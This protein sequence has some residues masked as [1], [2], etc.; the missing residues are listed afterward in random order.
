M[1]KNILYQNLDILSVMEACEDKSKDFILLFMPT[2]MGGTV[3][4][5]SRQRKISTAYDEWYHE[6][7]REYADF[8][9]LYFSD[10]N[11]YND[12]VT[13][14]KKVIQNAGRILGDEGIFCFAVPQVIKLLGYETLEALNVQ[15]LLEQTF[16]YC[17]ALPMPSFS[18]ET[19]EKIGCGEKLSTGR[20]FTVGATPYTLYVCSNC[21][22]KMC[23]RNWSIYGIK[24]PPNAIV[25]DFLEKNADEIT[26]QNYAGL[27]ERE[28][29]K[30]PGSIAIRLFNTL[31]IRELRQRNILEAVE[32]MSFSSY[33]IAGKN[34]EEI[35]QFENV[36]A[37]LR[38]DTLSILNDKN[39]WTSICECLIYTLYE[40]QKDARVLFPF[41]RN[42]EC[43]S[44]AN[45]LGLNW[46]SLYKISLCNKEIWY[47]GENRSAFDCPELKR[48]D[49]YPIRYQHVDYLK[50]IEPRDY[51]IQTTAKQ[52][53]TVYYDENVV[54]SVAEINKMKQRVAKYTSL[55]N[56][57]VKYSAETGDQGDPDMEEAVHSIIKLAVKG[58]KGTIKGDEAKNWYGDGWNKL[59]KKCQDYL[60]TAYAFEKMSQMNETAD[61][62]PIVIEYC[63]AVELEMNSTVI[64]PYMA[65]IKL[66]N[67][68][69]KY[70][71]NPSDYFQKIIDKYSEEPQ[72]AT[73]M[74]GEIGKSLRDAANCG[75]DD[76]HQTLKEYCIKGGKKHL[77]DSDNVGK[78]VLISKIRNQSAHPSAL[79]KG[80]V[81]QIRN[82]VRQG[83]KAQQSVNDKQPINDEPLVCAIIGPDGNKLAQSQ[84]TEAFRA[85]IRNQIS[86]L[87]QSRIQQFA[88][89][90]NTGF[91][92]IVSEILMDYKIES[93]KHKYVR[94]TEYLPCNRA[95]MKFPT[96]CRERALQVD[97]D[98]K[99]IVSGSI[100]NA[101]TR[102]ACQRKALEKAQFCIAYY[103]VG[104]GSKIEEMVNEAVR[105][106]GLIVWNAYGIG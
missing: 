70:G 59:S 90:G 94:L 77:L 35:A 9:R 79:D 65:S 91:E 86:V 97:T 53:S 33:R 69:K 95:T 40:Q 28:W 47:R 74:L 30:G 89:A 68:K 14:V 16:A 105:E 66:D 92:L 10:L 27:Y 37:K 6:N 5:S 1:D 39:N 4:E 85:A 31:L 32:K 29:L 67:G 42:A 76:I 103:K 100:D 60:Q 24:R 57:I 38:N 44:I 7:G 102:E 61:F 101:A 11:D 96:G 34:D 54:S 45:R 58:Q 50:N 20:H 2:T 73:M 36:Q 21:E 25:D 87:D 46:T 43:A 56:E 19:E 55:L 64:K 81:D 106:R 12:Y 98:A 26:R 3:G 51:E 83:L 75:P 15:V 63:R 13:L 41:D 84:N 88:S 72:T 99:V 52:V 104:G 78:Y 82:L 62:A 8:G 23:R 80:C 49:I 48:D 71:N 93:K 22:A 17:K 18:V